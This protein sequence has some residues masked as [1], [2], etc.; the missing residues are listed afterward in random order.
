[1]R[2]RREER[3]EKPPLPPR[4]AIFHPLAA[5]ADGEAPAEL[6]PCLRLLTWRLAHLGRK[7]PPTLRAD[8]E[9]GT[10]MAYVYSCD[11]GWT[12]RNDTPAGFVADVEAHI[13]DTHTDMVGKLSPE[14]IIALAEEQ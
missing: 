7:L 5:H 2:P 8:N 14:D 4:K 1:M 6:D 9:R 11:C 12:A 13:A 10:E 3:E